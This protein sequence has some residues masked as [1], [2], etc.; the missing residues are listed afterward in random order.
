MAGNSGVRR[1]GPLHII[2]QQYAH[3]SLWWKPSRGAGSDRIIEKSRTLNLLDGVCY[4]RCFRAVLG[5]EHIPFGRKRE[6]IL[7]PL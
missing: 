3:S 5:T 7:L 6:S 2:E 1:C 4:Q